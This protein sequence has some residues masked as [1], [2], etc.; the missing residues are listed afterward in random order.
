MLKEF[1]TYLENQVKNGSIYVLGA[2][3]Q[4]GSK[5]TEAWIKYREHYIS[6]N[7]KRAIALWKQ[8]LAQGY[9]ALCA[10]DC[11]GLGMY[12]LYNVKRIFT[13]DLNANGMKSKCQRIL[14][15]QIKVGD[16]VFRVNS[17]G[18]AH[19]IGYVVGIG[20]DGI[21][22][23]IE[24]MGR[25]AGVVKRGLNASGVSYWNYAGRPL[26]F[27]TEI[28]GQTDVSSYPTLKKGMYDNQYV[29]ILQMELNERGYGLTADGDFG[30]K[31]ETAV[32]DYQSKNGLKDDGIV[33]KLT[34]TS[35]LK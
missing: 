6:A 26:I 25:S 31:T 18:R 21:P 35:L 4:T 24:S 10:Y 30:S 29:K 3:G 1:L 23:V 2:Q 13:G 16:W 22:I 7:Y 12:F 34:W 32:K 27:K 19:H 33:G 8:R 17:T 15:S 28:E 20:T 9:L 11:S 14:R 5:I